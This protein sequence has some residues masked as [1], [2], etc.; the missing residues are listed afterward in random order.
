MRG[1]F[2]FTLFISILSG[3]SCYAQSR[4]ESGV[5]TA[6]KKYDRLILKMNPDSIAL[7]YSADGELGNMATGRDSIRNFLNRFNNFKVLMQDS[8]TSFIT[9]NR[10]TAF[11][12][13]T[14]H[15]KV[16]IPSGDTVSVKGIFNVKWIWTKNIW[17]IKLMDTQPSN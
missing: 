4:N 6:M 15:Q 10:D 9:I 7:F 11:Q 5:E 14:Y 2:Y 12:T 8:K 16:I 1:T 3:L 17:Q 13:G